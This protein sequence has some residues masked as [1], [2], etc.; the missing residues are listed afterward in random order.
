MD[1]ETAPVDLSSNTHAQ[2]PLVGF[3][4]HIQNKHDRRVMLFGKADVYTYFAEFN[5]L[6]ESRTRP[7]KDPWGRK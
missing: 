3:Q 5:T 7:A 1:G 6:A 4:D 2:R